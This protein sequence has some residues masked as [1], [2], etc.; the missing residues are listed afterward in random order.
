MDSSLYQL[1]QESSS[2][3]FQPALAKGNQTIAAALLLALGI[4]STG[5]FA[6]SRLYPIG[7]AGNGGFG[8]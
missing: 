8:S 3:L 5:L 2:D 7:L 6:L 1:W 4:T